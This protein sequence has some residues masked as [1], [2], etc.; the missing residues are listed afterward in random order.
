MMEKT[1]GYDGHHDCVG[2]GENYATCVV[3][4]LTKRLAKRAYQKDI[5][6][7]SNL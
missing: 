4:V 1:Y 3:D 2:K 6:S 5:E 7:V